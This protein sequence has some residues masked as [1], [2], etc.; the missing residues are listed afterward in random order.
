MHEIMVILMIMG[1]LLLDYTGIHSACDNDD[2]SDNI[3][4]G[5][6]AVRLHRDTQCMR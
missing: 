2:N 1:I 3:D 4:N 6:P 5:G